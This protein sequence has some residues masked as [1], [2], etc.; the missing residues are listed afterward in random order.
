MSISFEAASIFGCGGVG[1]NVIQTAK[2]SGASK[3]IPIDINQNQTAFTHESDSAY[4]FTENQQHISPLRF[5]CRVEDPLF[6]SNQLLS[7]QF[8]ELKITYQFEAFDG[9]HEW[10]YWHQHVAK[11]FTFFDQLEKQKVSNSITK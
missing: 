7:K 1:L 2:Q 11:T 8:D 9:G 6:K 10:A 3:I 4:W 5:D